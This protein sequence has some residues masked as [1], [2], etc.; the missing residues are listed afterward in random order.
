VSTLYPSEYFMD[1]VLRLDPAAGTIVAVLEASRG[2]WRTK[3]LEGSGDEFQRRRERLCVIRNNSPVTHARG[4]AL[5]TE[6]EEGRRVTSRRSRR[7]PGRP[8][9]ARVRGDFQLNGSKQ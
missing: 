4:E 6:A 5:R 1:T 7:G 2:L 8:D 9:V 3:Q